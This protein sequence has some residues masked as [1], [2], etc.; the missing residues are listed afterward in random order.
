MKKARS[1]HIDAEELAAWEAEA[2]ASGLSFN[3]WVTWALR[4]V[5]ALARLER[6]EAEQAAE[7]ERRQSVV[8]VGKPEGPPLSDEDYAARVRGQRRARGW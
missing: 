2:K 1:I 8:A 5:Y 6:R 3:G 7:R 4:Q